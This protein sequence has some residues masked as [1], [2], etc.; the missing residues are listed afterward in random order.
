MFSALLKELKGAVGRMLAMAACGLVAAIAGVIALA[1]LLLA[2]FVWVE[3][4]YDT[5]TAALAVAI[6]FIVVAIIVLIVMLILR[7]TA[8]KRAQKSRQRWWADPAVVA[9]GVE[10]VR[11]L[12]ARKVIP[13][14]AIAAV[15]LGI[16]QSTSRSSRPK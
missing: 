4:T 7:G 1:F 6:F 16:L 11:M 3:N 9:T 15:I 10:L 2:A 14:A 12:G 13:A 8:R 5:I